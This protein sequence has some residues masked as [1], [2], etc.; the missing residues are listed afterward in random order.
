M[1]MTPKP[2]SVEAL[3]IRIRSMIQ[4]RRGEALR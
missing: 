2:A 3:A 1:E 4:L